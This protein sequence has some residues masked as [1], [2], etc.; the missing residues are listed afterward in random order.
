MR[1]KNILRNGMLAAS[2]VLLFS[3]C[4]NQKDSEPVVAMQKGTLKIAYVDIDSVS[5]N[6]QLCKDLNAALQKKSDNAQATLI[7]KNKDLQT[8]YQQVQSQVQANALTREQYEAA[9]HTLQARQQDLQSLQERL[10][11]E[12]QEEQAKA[13]KEELDS[14][15]NFITA[16]NKTKGYNIILRKE[17]T[18]YV[19]KTFDITNDIINGLNKK[20]KKRTSTVVS[21]KVD[22]DTKKK[23]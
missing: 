23:K 15:N 17:V 6:Y 21:A 9:Q 12:F 14:I 4:N 3:Q 18:L 1:K 16:Y 7:K 10:N 20:Y 19:D 13:L 11:S 2:A 22:E 5:A 8:Y